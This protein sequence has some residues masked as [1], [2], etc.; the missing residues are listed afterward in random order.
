MTEGKNRRWIWTITL[1]EQRTMNLDP[2]PINST[3]VNKHKPQAA[4]NLPVYSI[5]G[6][7]HWSYSGCNGDCRERSLSL[8]VLVG[9]PGK[10]K[11]KRQCPLL[12]PL[13]CGLQMVWECVHMCAYV[14]VCVCVCVDGMN[15][16]YALRSHIVHSVLCQYTVLDTST[17][18]L[19]TIWG[20]RT[21]GAKSGYCH[22]N[23]PQ[24][25]FLI[26][27]III[28]IL[29]EWSVQSHLIFPISSTFKH[30]RGATTE[31]YN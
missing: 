16:K 18:H 22:Q 12:A 15:L 17:M 13:V 4:T 9:F 21:N 30:Q 29:L 11:P 2:L 26:L 1:Q 28:T 10:K 25:R 7:A 14:C 24:L 19:Q 27:L 3:T 23:M 20:Q 8:H 31:E 5:H 6:R